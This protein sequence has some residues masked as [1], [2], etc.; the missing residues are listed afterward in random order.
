MKRVRKLAYA[1]L[2]LVVP[3]AAVA[4][5]LLP[6]SAATAGPITG[7]GGKCI[8]VAGASS[9]NGTAVQLYDCNGSSAQQWSVGNTDGSIR[10]LGKCMDVANGSTTNGA[11]I[12]L[13]DCNA[14]GAQKWT[15][16]NGALV[17]TGSGKCLDVTGKSS[18]NG[19]R[20]QI[21]DCAG[22]ANQQWTLP[23]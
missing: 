20:L 5:G 16:S 6:A 21:W 18:A 17:N 9:A 23:T 8:D 12:Q 19:T 11:K 22:S 14:T 10:A 13:Y 4:Y 1:S 3:A 15:V 7:L 2:G